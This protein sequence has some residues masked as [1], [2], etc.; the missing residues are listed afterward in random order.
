M[1]KDHI[2]RVLLIN[3]NNRDYEAIEKALNAIKNTK[4][5]LE[6]EPNYEKALDAI[7]KDLHDVYIVDFQ[8]ENHTGL[9]L[10]QEVVLRDIKV[11][12]IIYAEDDDEDLD[13][14]SM[15][16]GA[17]DYIVKSEI[18]PALLERSIRYSYNNNEHIKK[19]TESEYK[20]RSLFERSV[21][22]LFIASKEYN[23]EEVND[24]FLKLMDCTR[25]SINKITLPDIFHKNE[26]Y[27]Y[28]ID[29]ILREYPLRGWEVVL[30]TPKGKKIECQLAAV[31]LYNFRGNI[32][33]Y[34]CIIHDLTLRKR[35]ERE[36]LHAELLSVTGKMARSMAHEVRN[37]LTNL[38]LA[39]EQLKSEINNDE[40]EMLGDIIGRNAKRI[41]T[42]ITEMLNNSQL[43]ELILENINLTELI[44][45]SLETVKDRILL[46]EIALENNIDNTI[47]PIPLDKGKMNIALTNLLINA[48]EA[49]EEQ[50]GK[51]N[52]E[53]CVK[54]ENIL[55]KISD[56]GKGI[57]EDSI[58]KL[59]NPFFT[60]KHGGMGLG[61]TNT[62]NII[63][64]HGGDIHIESQVGEGTTF[65]INLP[66]RN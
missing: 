44:E 46:K 43:D 1:T 60:K 13:V 55:I 42:I 2:I 52:L 65:I 41:D 15:K 40:A 36:L 27:L 34:Q 31:P 16:Q 9:D 61:L 29:S 21:D 59:F 62:K 66:I 53:S 14:F 28:F 24:S 38:T 25:E 6:Q 50:H 32:T 37:P 33:G 19:I 4:Y 58:N 51:L 23:I 49:M 26:D 22:A 56:N 18:T 11:P 47:P 10:I 17:A 63:T 7:S 57:D 39:L 20:F 48:I 8:L 45:E 35:A 12:V 64:A 3:N 5:K 54:D 30:V